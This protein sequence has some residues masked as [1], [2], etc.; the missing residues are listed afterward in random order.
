MRRSGLWNAASRWLPL[1]LRLTAA[2]LIAV[3][4]SRRFLDEGACSP[5]EACPSPR[6]GS[7][8]WCILACAA[9]VLLLLGAAARIT[10]IVG[11]SLLGISQIFTPLMP[12]QVALA[13]LY[14]AVLYLGS[15][16]MSLWT[17]ENRLIYRRAGE[18]RSE[19][20]TRL[21]LRGDLICD[22]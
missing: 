13:V 9:A 2:G 1:L 12:V 11:L 4:L 8:S 3:S 15:G 17:P 20:K 16:A 14:T 22:G 6:R 21:P 7:S 10:A 5:P 18:R 19:L